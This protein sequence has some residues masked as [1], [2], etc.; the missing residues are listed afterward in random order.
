[1]RHLLPSLFA[2]G[3]LAALF[4]APAGAQTA[5]ALDPAFDSDGRVDIKLVA[6][7]GD[8]A[9]AILNYPG[10]RYLAAARCNDASGSTACFARFNEDGTPD[11]SF[12]SSGAKVIQ[13][14]TGYRMYSSAVALQPDG[15]ILVAGRCTP[16]AGGNQLPCHARLLADGSIDS[17]Y[18]SAGGVVITIANAGNG[19]ANGIA[20][21]SDGKIVVG[22]NCFDTGYAFCAWRYGANGAPDTS[23]GAAGVARAGLT[24]NSFGATSMMLTPDNMAI[25]VGYCDYGSSTS[26]VCLVRFTAAGARDTG[27]VGGSAAPSLPH[28]TTGSVYEGS[29]ASVLQPDGR[30]VVGGY[31]GNGGN[32]RFCA[33]RVTTAGALDTSFAGGW[34]LPTHAALG[35]QSMT[36]GVALQRDGKI[37]YTIGCVDR[38]KICTLRMNSDGSLDTL[39]GTGGVSAVTTSGFATEV[40]G[41][42]LDGNER[43]LIAGGCFGNDG[44]G[45]TDTCLWRVQ[46]GQSYAG[47]SCSFDVDDDGA[48]LTANDV[49][50]MT[51]AAMGFSGTAVTAG[52]TMPAAAR[53]TAWTDI[54]DYLFNQCGMT[55]LR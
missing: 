25:L 6:G 18:G 46:R 7:N 19:M 23:Y 15:K 53:R 32:L 45:I 17:S 5:G 34:S 11:A 31:C 48:A 42:L 37:V 44:G 4:T 16:A 9:F 26:N 27:Y 55:R 1:M 8:T 43:L 41:A 22:G 14:I 51:R 39:Y 38:Y 2:A 49:L 21:Q 35:A 29:T 36:G 52:I 54:R 50:I 24:P 28:H 20:V 47:R 30:V 3:A 33:A 13:P 40:G 12:G 10:R